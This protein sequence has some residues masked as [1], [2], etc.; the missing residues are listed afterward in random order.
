MQPMGTKHT[1][2][3]GIIAFRLPHQQ[4]GRF[5][6]QGVGRVRVSEQLRKKDFENVDHIIHWR[7]CLVDHVQAN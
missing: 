1:F 5:T 2:D 7:P 3:F 4:S 6:I